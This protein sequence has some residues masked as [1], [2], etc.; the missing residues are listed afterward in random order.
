MAP[1]FRGVRDRADAPT[2]FEP[3]SPSHMPDDSTALRA[4]ATKCRRLARG[5]SMSDVAVTLGQMATDY[6]RQADAAAT[7][8]A[9]GVEAEATV[10]PEAEAPPNA[11]PPSRLS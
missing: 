1:L 8:E 6:D 10:E 9:E 4:L 3:R 2:P 11:P 7:V 5:V